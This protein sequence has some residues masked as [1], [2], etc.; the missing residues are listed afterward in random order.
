MESA[1]SRAEV[2]LHDFNRYRAHTF[3]IQRL[4]AVQCVRE[5]GPKKGLP[6]FEKLDAWCRTYNIDA[7]RWLYH[8]FKVKKW[9]H[10][11][12][13]TTLIPSKRSLK[14]RWAAYQEMTDTPFFAATIRQEIDAR[15][16][17][18]G[19]VVDRN[20]DLIPMAEILKRR[21]LGESRPDKCL[22][23]MWEQTFGYHP[24]SQVCGHCP[25]AARCAGELQASVTFDIM[26]LRRGDLTLQEA[27][28]IASRA[29]HAN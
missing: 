10:A 2:L 16:R 22:N 27:Q 21:Y 6:I 26:A 25:L 28:V 15:R 5:L 1:T 19:N 13:L 17:E 23:E 8:L 7:R 20:R 9:I 3:H 24:K 12:V 4:R 29:S 14:K 11:P 18:T